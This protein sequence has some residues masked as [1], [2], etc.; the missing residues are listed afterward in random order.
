MNSKSYSDDEIDLLE[1]LLGVRARLWVVAALVGVG[2]LLGSLVDRP[3]IYD[4]R[5]AFEISDPNGKFGDPASDPAIDR[6]AGSRFIA[7]V[8]EKAVGAGTAGAL[9]GAEDGAADLDRFQAMYRDSVTVSR[10]PSGTISVLVSHPDPSAA[11]LLAN[12]TV[13]TA[14]ESLV[15]ERGETA[16]I[17]F[18][19]ASRSIAE[20]ASRRDEASLSLRRAVEAG[21]SEETIRQRQA[22][23]ANARAAHDLLVE[24]FNAEVTMAIALPEVQII[25]EASVPSAP[26]PK[27]L[28][29]SIVFGAAGGVG[30]L[31]L[32]GLWAIASGRIHSTG[33]M[34]RF[35]QAG[36]TADAVGSSGQVGQGPSEGGAFSVL[37]PGATD[38]LIALRS[39][40]SDV[41]VVAATEE[42]L[43]PLPVAVWLA[44]RL[45]EG[46]GQV[47]VVAVNLSVP[48][49]AEKVGA[50]M[51]TE[52]RKL[53]GVE[54][55][56][57][58]GAFDYGAQF[59]DL[60]A[61]LT[62]GE[63]KGHVIIACGSEWSKTVLRMV[64]DHH[65]MVLAVTGRGK[66]RRATLAA[67]RQIAA[68]DVNIMLKT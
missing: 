5:A 11:A 29:P 12:V 68:I 28:S 42:T 65:P 49:S 18:E 61:S 24:A 36:I 25:E 17:W 46:G 3:T 6:L 19:N 37:Q 1:L 26:R 2:F 10:L 21:E 30:G 58:S 32:A 64:L 66:T 57:P 54:V 43:S 51:M 22:D 34:R 38:I 20:A 33:T 47:S 4:A 8:F 16:E 62:R 39:R 48:E 44:R 52:Q 23:L 56:V 67:I 40:G 13:E 9:I 59:P 14:M 35:A 27:G 60:L 63:K 50:S 7:E 53:D 55:V 15:R 41:T 45:I 31:L